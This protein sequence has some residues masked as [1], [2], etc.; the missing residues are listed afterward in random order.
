M[1][2]NIF[3]VQPDDLGYSLVSKGNCTIGPCRNLATLEEAAVR[4]FA[5][6]PEKQNQA[7][8]AIEEFRNKK[9]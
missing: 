9:D 6:Q 7:K 5:G 3:T 2:E 1:A 8:K 4:A